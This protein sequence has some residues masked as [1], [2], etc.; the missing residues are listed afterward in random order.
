MEREIKTPT[1]KKNVANDLHEAKII[2]KPGQVYMVKTD[3]NGDEILG[4]GS[5]TSLKTF[6]TSFSHLNFKI[7]KK[8]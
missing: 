3:K 8:G 4:T 5:I 2:L 1:I 7:K 6:Q